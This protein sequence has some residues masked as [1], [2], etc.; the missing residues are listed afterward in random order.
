M[1][2]RSLGSTGLELSV[3]G[4]GCAQLGMVSTDYGVKLVRRA[5]ELGINWFDAARVYR[6]A[7]VKI[8]LALTPGERKDVILSTKVAAKTRD[9]ARQQIEESLE[10]M[11]TDYLDNCH[12]HGLNLGEDMD[13]RLGEGGALEAL[14]EARDEGLV[15]HI[16]CTAHRAEAL[17]EALARYDFE[18][19][20]VPMNI[21]NRGPLDELIPLCGKKGV[22]VTIMKGLA[23]GL[24]PAPLA[25]KWLLEQPIASVASGITSLEQLEENA[26]V[27]D[28]GP[29]LTPAEA[30]EV[31]RLRGYWRQRRCRL[32]NLC[33]PCPQGIH[34][35][36][37]LGTDVMYDHFRTLGPAAFKAFPWAPEVIAEERESR[38]KA[39]ERISACDDCGQCEPRCPYGLP[40]VRMLRDMVPGMEQMVAI[41][42]ELGG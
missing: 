19:I 42:D 29:G 35:G 25:L 11:R 10:R 32:C 15:R 20:L 22:G 6:D 39:I 18:T 36:M 28:A 27:G 26:R 7:E 16:G 12:I 8:G 4:F 24:L 5:L 33:E 31:R 41:Y 21:V 9:E 30:A 37:R 14:I 38:R 34:I 17:I 1:R 40:I 23:T 3:I 13:R 2:H